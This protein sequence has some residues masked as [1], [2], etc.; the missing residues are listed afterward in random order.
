MQEL[1]VCDSQTG[2]TEVRKSPHREMEPSETDLQTISE[3]R[4]SAM[5][6]NGKPA[7]LW[8]HTQRM[9]LPANLVCVY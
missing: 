9:E 1:L 3:K 7:A 8:T 4:R 5:A 6:D 2:S